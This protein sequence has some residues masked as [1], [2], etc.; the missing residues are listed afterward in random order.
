[1][2]FKST[3][4]FQDTEVT[5]PTPE[6]RPKFYPLRQV[7]SPWWLALYQYTFL[8]SSEFGYRSC[9]QNTNRDNKRGSHGKERRE[10][11]Q[12]SCEKTHR[13]K[14]D[15]HQNIPV[16]AP[17]IQNPQALD[18]DPKA[19]SGWG[20]KITSSTNDTTHQ[21]NKTKNPMEK[22]TNVPNRHFPKPDIKRAT[23][24]GGEKKKQ[25]TSIT[26]KERNA[27]PNYSEVPPETCPNG[28]S[29]STINKSR[30]KCWE[31]GAL[32]KCGFPCNLVP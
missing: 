15:A 31:E 27:Y 24:T 8:N 23:S 7:G 32:Q 20:F 22:S 13:D 19:G 11:Q 18:P 4:G 26:P 14:P 1:M 25:K 6:Q 17:S 29:K 5:K 2:R 3:R 21:Q 28:I 16:L 10:F 30:G 12:I 9:L